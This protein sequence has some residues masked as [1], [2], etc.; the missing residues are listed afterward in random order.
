LVVAWS[1]AAKL[2]VRAERAEMYAKSRDAHKALRSVFDSELKP[3]GYRRWKPTSASYFIQESS[4]TPF[5]R[6]NV[7]L[8][9]WGDSWSGNSFT[10][11]TQ[12]GEGDPKADSYGSR[13]VG[14]YMSLSE[15]AVAESISSSIF[16]RKPTPAKDHW[17]HSEIEQEESPEGL[18]TAA[19]HR[20]FTYEPG[21]YQVGHDIWFD[22]YSVKDL[23]EWAAYLVPILRRI[24]ES[25]EGAL[26]KP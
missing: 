17:I 25:G 15:L 21:Q 4:V 7:Q 13:R 2:N 9:Q 24:R 23:T 10:V 26:T 1:L 5:F 3:L 16:A 11:N 19:Y 22:Y 6:F 12:F 14:D 20:A 18:W 8:S